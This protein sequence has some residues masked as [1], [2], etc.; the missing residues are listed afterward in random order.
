MFPSGF[1]LTLWE[2]GKVPRWIPCN[3]KVTF[4]ECYRK[5]F[6]ADLCV[7]LQKAPW[8]SLCDITVTFHEGYSEATAERSLVFFMYHLTLGWEFQR[9]QAKS[10]NAKYRPREFY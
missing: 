5:T 3:F 7:L 8:W 2:G 10:F 9:F 1:R 6:P 4:S